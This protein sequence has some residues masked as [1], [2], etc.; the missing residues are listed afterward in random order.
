VVLVVTVMVM[1]GE[2]KKTENKGKWGLTKNISWFRVGVNEREECQHVD[3]AAI[4]DKRVEGPPAYACQE[5]KE[6]FCL[7]AKRG[8]A[9][10]KD[11]RYMCGRCRKNEPYSFKIDLDKKKNSINGKRKKDNKNKNHNSRSKKQKKRKEKP[12]K[13]KKKTEDIF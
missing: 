8:V 1:L 12:R 10:K 13:N 6:R 2:S 4:A 3:E 7:C 11:W 5:D 9:E